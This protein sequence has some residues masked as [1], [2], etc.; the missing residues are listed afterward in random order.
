MAVLTLIK[1]F[2]SKIQIYL[3]WHWPF[4]SRDVTSQVTIWYSGC[5]FL[6]MPYCNRVCTSSHFRQWAPKIL[7]S[8]TWPFK[9]TWRN[10]SRFRDIRPQIPCAHLDTDRHAVS[11]LFRP[12]QCTALDWQKSEQKLAPK[13]TL[14]K[15]TTVVPM[16]LQ[17]S[18]TTPLGYACIGQQ[19]DRLRF[20]NADISRSFLHCVQKKHPLTYSFVS[21]WMMSRFK[22]KLQWIYPRKDRLWKCR[23]H[24]FIAADDVIMTSHL[25][26]WSWSEFTARNKPGVQDIIFVCTGYLLVRILIH[27]VYYVMEFKN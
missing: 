11:D 6:C 7:R 20:M 9:V 26:G 10:R 3:A 19:T 8:R 14:R 25:S 23:N 15:Q 16:K 24:I 1:I 5:H 27:V 22:Q 12:M 2:P 18:Q 4:R 13:S 21:P 17:A